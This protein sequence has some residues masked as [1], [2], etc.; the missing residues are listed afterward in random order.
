MRG[1]PSGPPR[2]SEDGGAG[3][4]DTEAEDNGG[5]NGY[6][7]VGECNGAGPDNVA[8][9]ASVA[10]IVSAEAKARP[11][12]VTW[13]AGRAGVD[14]VDVG[15]TACTAAAAAVVED[16]EVEAEAAAL[17]AGSTLAA[18]ILRG[19][20]K[21][22]REVS[23]ACVARGTSRL[24]CGSSAPPTPLCASHSSCGMPCGV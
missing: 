6:L 17:P 2:T 21:L 15:A 3:E 19:A 13:R 5:T 20:L 7:G 12:V 1:E 9:A 8:G 11:G 24:P 4:G 23:G 16:A 14:V 10:G 18:P 22:S